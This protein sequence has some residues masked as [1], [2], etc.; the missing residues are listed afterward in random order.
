MDKV[1]GIFARQPEKCRTDYF[2]FYMFHNVYEGNVGDY[3]DPRFG[4]MEHLLNMK[5]EGNIRHLG[6]SAH[7]AMD[8]LKRFLDTCGEHMEFCL[9]QVNYM[10]WH[11]QDAQAKVELM[12]KNGI[13]VTVMEPLRGEKQSELSPNTGAVEWTFRFLQSVP[14]L[15]ET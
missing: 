2:D 3:T 4:I 5:K 10:D 6:F 12:A 15:R 13:P 7:G 1:K 14:D 9:L 8:V 11:F